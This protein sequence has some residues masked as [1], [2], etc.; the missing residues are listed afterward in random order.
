MVVTPTAAMPATMP[1]QMVV[2][3]ASVAAPVAAIDTVH[4]PLDRCR[5][6]GDAGPFDR[7]KEHRA[8]WLTD[9]ERAALAAVVFKGPDLQ[10]RAF[11]MKR[12][13]L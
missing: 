4:P 3:S 6:G 5:S 9:A 7:P 12:T 1:A 10:R 2:L 8:E 13:T 11:N